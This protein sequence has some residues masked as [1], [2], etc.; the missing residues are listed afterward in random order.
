MDFLGKEGE[1]AAHAVQNISERIEKLESH[2]NALD[3]AV[4]DTKNE[5]RV[6]DFEIASKNRDRLIQ[7][8]ELI[9]QLAHIQEKNLTQIKSER[10]KENRL[11][12]KINKLNQSLNQI[13]NEQSRLESELNEIKEKISSVEKNLTSE[14]GLN[15]KRIESKV[16]EKSLNESLDVLKRDVSRLKSSVSILADEDEESKIIIE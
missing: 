15:Q 8:E 16:S 3:N 1:K 2:I 13:E 7:L 11:E 10:S 9:S 4:Q 12:K 6:K 14:I 5:S